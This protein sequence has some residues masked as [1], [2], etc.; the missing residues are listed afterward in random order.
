MN[1]VTSASGLAFVQEWEGFRAAPAQL[2]DGNWLIG[3]G[4]VRSEAGAQVTELEA[5]ELLV[6]D[7]ALVEKLVNGALTQ[8]VS[9]A[10][11]DA[12]VS[13]AFSI[14]AASFLKSQVLRRLNA[15]SFVAAA[16]AM[17]AW[18]KSDGAGEAQICEAL[19]LRRAAE[20]ALFLKDVSV[21][22]APSALVRPQLDYAASVLGA[23]AVFAEL[24]ALTEAAVAAQIAAT[25]Q[26]ELSEA[27]RL[28]KILMSEPA[29]EVLLLT[30]VVPEP[31]NDEDEIVTAH[32]KPVARDTAGVIKFDW[33]RF[34][35][36]AA[37]GIGR[38]PKVR[39]AKA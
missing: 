4:H 28:T 27:Q 3:Y 17:D 9:Q 18:R 16:C 6:R 22:R 24:P 10:Q 2:P 13:F 39:M 33:R 21:A 23:P 38:A 30:Q 15:G 1:Y 5:T 19:V 34:D 31:S 37:L 26:P 25:Q 36:L 7:L 8:S 35:V 32:A 14:G 12:L 29:T 11:F 20:K